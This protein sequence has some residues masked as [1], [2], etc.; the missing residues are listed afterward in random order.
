MTESVKRNVK[1]TARRASRSAKTATT[2]AER[3]LGL[4]DLKGFS[5]ILVGFLRGLLHAMLMAAIT[6]VTKELA[7]L[8][9][10]G[11]I[12]T[13]AVVAVGAVRSLEGVL[14]KLLLGAPPQ[15]RLLGGKDAG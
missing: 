6:Y 14:D 15:A 7:D 11:A 2:A 3:E 4:D 1:S 5:P 8:G 13:V 9:S 12:G 10:V